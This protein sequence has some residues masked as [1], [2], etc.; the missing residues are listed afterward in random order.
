MGKKV[1]KDLLGEV[2]FK[3]QND[4]I[5]KKGTKN[6]LKSKTQYIRN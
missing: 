4:Q 5:Y 1:K 6:N 3:K 2:G